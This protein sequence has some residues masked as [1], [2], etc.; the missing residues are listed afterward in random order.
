M[1]TV[2]NF[3]FFAFSGNAS[4]PTLVRLCD[5]HPVISSVVEKSSLH[6]VLPCHF[7]GRLPI[8]LCHTYGAIPVCKKDPSASLGM[9]IWGK[10]LS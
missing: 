6:S 5:P 4:P 1:G 7:H 9:T 10:R 3:L 2:C 8:L